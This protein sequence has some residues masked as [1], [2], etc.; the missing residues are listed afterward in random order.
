MLIFIAGWQIA[1]KAR[2]PAVLGQVAAAYPSIDRSTLYSGA[3]EGGF[4]Y[5]LS[6]P[7][8]MSKPSLPIAANGEVTLIAGAA[9]DPLGR[10]NPMHAQ[11]LASNFER[12]T[13]L[14]GQFV[15]LRL[16]ADGLELVN[17]PFGVLPVFVW[18][19][20]QGCLISN[21]ATALA[22]LG[23]MAEFDPLG[24]SSYVGGRCVA[25]DRTLVRQVMVLPGG[26]KWR[27]TSRQGVRE[28]SYYDY[29][30]AAQQPSVAPSESWLAQCAAQLGGQL[31]RLTQQTQALHIPISAGRDTRVM[32]ALSLAERLDASYFTVGDRS[33]VDVRVGKDIAA[34][35]G[36]KHRHDEIHPD[37]ISHNWQELA[38]RVVRRNDG[39]VT[40]AHIRNALE[41]VSYDHLPMMLYGNGG[42]IAR[43]YYHDALSCF[44][45]ANG[46]QLYRQLHS[47]MVGYPTTL[48]TDAVYEQVRAY[49]RG[50]IDDH[51]Q[52]GVAASAIPDLFYLQEIA[53]RWGGSQSRQPCNSFEVFSPFVTRPYV[54]AAFALSAPERV[55]E[56]LPLGLIRVTAP[57]L[58][59]VPFDQPLKS[60][61]VSVLRRKMQRERRITVLKAEA[62]KLGVVRVLKQLRRASSPKEFGR[63]EERAHW[64]EASLEVIRSFCL[65][66]TS[67]QLWRYVSRRDFELLMQPDNL[68]LRQGRQERLY[69]IVTAFYYEQYLQ[70]LLRQPAPAPAR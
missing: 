42:E 51:L 49:L 7:L 21:S 34:R 40:L 56:V 37:E 18:R 38:E 67:S 55:M 6:A 10:F 50:F 32:V 1:Q 11:E 54:H 68:A 28:E 45:R 2:V 41:T 36:L 24:I 44:G 60:Q 57:E 14:E 69:C 17:D 53:R 12:A 15:A 46:A 5:A 43:G 23:G 9:V 3:C 39:M 61:D 20:G 65:D 64:F 47:K 13:E 66:Q 48:L 63:L 4:V 52:R 62:R 8:A 70:S 25:A 59:R 26:Q 35:Y 30:T 31:A 27:W 19:H 16:T 22:V 33:R 58:A 29:T